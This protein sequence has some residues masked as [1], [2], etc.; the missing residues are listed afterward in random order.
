MTERPFF[1]IT[2][3]ADP[4][5]LAQDRWTD[6]STLAYVG[7]DF[8]CDRPVDSPTELVAALGRSTQT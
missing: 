6:G 5:P 3:P 2:D 1:R 8:V 7:E 4:V